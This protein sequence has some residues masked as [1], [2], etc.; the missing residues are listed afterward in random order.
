M[1]EPASDSNHKI[2]LPTVNGF[3][4]IDYTHIIYCK[5]ESSQSSIYLDGEKKHIIV[6]LT[7]KQLE[8]MLLPH[9]YFRIHKSYLINTG[10]FKLYTRG[11]DG[12]VLMDNGVTLPVSRMHKKDFEERFR[13][14]WE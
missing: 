11:R 13:G 5:G 6:C 8:K 9:D 1:E 14:M 12:K 2:P 4:M 3:E 7:L 10:H